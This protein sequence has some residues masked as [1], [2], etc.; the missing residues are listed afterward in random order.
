MVCND[1]FPVKVHN[2]YNLVGGGYALD[3]DVHHLG[4]YHGVQADLVRAGK[5]VAL[6]CIAYSL[7]PHARY[8]T[9]ICE[10]V[11]ALNYLLEE[12]GR[13][14]S[15]IIIGG[16]SAGAAISLAIV[17]HLSHPSPDFPS[18]KDHGKIKAIVL[19]AP[20]TS[21]DFGW[22]S[23]KGNIHKD[24]LALQ[25]LQE[26]SAE[27]KAGKASNNFM[28]A[29]E[30]PA[31]WWEGVHVEDLLCTAGGEEIFLDSIS[32]WVE[33]YRV[34]VGQSPLILGTHDH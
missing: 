6:L 34:S 30:A 3:G 25:K 14:T 15:E 29:V 23:Y 24:C 10:G 5:S 32:A 22:P 1:H 31:N 12:K 17:S 7:T 11:E 27:Y 21:F 26:W 20:W 2:I 4:F 16:D 18:V 13:S 19:M 28:E 9:Q 33:K 8:P